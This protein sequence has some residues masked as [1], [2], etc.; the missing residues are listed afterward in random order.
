MLTAARWSSIRPP[1]TRMI[2]EKK[3]SSGTVAPV[4]DP[5]RPAFGLTLG[6]PF[7]RSKVAL[8]RGSSERCSSRRVLYT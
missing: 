4:F 7:S 6:S 1:C 2:N 8:D 5:P 3:S